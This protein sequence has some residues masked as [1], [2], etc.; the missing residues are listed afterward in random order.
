M[1]TVGVEIEQESLVVLYD[2]QTGGIVHGHHFV[3]V[4]GGQHPDEKSRE[5]QAR[6]HARIAHANLPGRIGTLHIEPTAFKQGVQYKV[7]HQKK[8]LVEI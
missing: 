5:K 6:E 7:D 8:T 2:E 3:T 1:S 4:R